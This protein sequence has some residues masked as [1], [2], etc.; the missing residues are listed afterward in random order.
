MTSR[1]YF[2]RP[3]GVVW[4]QH[5]P[6]LTGWKGLVPDRSL[7]LINHSPTGFNWGYGG[8]GPAQLALALLLEETTEEEALA[9]Y[10]QFKWDVVAKW[11]T[12]KNWAYPASKIQRWL[13]DHR[14]E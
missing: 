1:T 14:K 9:N 4:R 6:S 8:S 10:Q 13:V 2:G 7:L 12:G 5:G 3:G 11:P